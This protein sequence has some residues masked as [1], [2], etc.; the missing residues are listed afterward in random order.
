MGG[1]EAE[2]D[3]LTRDA[4]NG[5]RASEFALLDSGEDAGIADECGGG[6]VSEAGNAENMH[7]VV[8]SPERG[9]KGS[10]K[11]GGVRRWSGGR[12]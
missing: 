4:C 11:R 1:I 5:T 3:G 2:A 6:I 7:R 9:G 8:F 12:W 10:G